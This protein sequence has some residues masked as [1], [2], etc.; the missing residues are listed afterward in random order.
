MRADGDVT[1]LSGRQHNTVGQRRGGEV[2]Q[3][4][5]LHALRL[6]PARPAT[7]DWSRAPTT[8]CS[9]LS[10]DEGEPVHFRVREEPAGSCVG[11]DDTV[12]STWRP[13][14]RR[15]DHHLA[16]APPRPGTYAPTGS[17]PAAPCTRRGRLRRR[18]GRRH[19]TGAPG[20]HGPG[21]APA[22]DFTG[23]RD[24]DGA[25]AGVQVVEPPARHERPGA[26][27]RPA[28]ADGHLPPGRTLAALRRARRPGRTS[29]GEAS[30]VPPTT[31]HPT[32][33]DGT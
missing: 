21:A 14:A 31:A 5:L 17:A 8:R 24:L 2:R 28:D 25:G 15:G 20:R 33:G 22:G 3:V 13:V 32:T 19:P 11:G 4:R 23:L 18:P 7:S 1:L 26:P 9:P 29:S 12:L 27:H 6:Q 10:D 30:Q 16:D